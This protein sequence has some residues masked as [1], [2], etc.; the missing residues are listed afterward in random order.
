[1]ASGM[2]VVTG[3]AGHVVAQ[4]DGHDH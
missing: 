4:L 2:D 3:I 1:V